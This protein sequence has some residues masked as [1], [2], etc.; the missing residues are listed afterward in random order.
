MAVLSRSRGTTFT[1]KRTPGSL[2]MPAHTRTHT[3]EN[4]QRN[5]NSI[6][7][8]AKL[9]L[10]RDRESWPLSRLQGIVLS[11]SLAVFLCAFVL[12]CLR[13]SWMAVVNWQKR[14]GVGHTDTYIHTYI[15]TRRVLRWGKLRAAA[16]EVRFFSLTVECGW[17]RCSFF[18]SFFF[19]V[20]V[21]F[22][23]TNVI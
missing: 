23:A 6:L 21:F 1:R 16:K 11:F 8:E 22:F 9:E 19:I 10:K 2:M 14:D 7:I 4:R 17:I 5:S 12:L 20:G 13:E 15:H 3:C 18:F